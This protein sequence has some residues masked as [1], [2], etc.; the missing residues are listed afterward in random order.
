MSKNDGIEMTSY[1]SA[2]TRAK[3]LARFQEN[4]IRRLGEV[5]DTHLHMGNLSPKGC[6]LSK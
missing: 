3:K 6:T 1:T 2:Y 5:A 4:W